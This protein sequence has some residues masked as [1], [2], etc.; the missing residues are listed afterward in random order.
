MRLGSSCFVL[1][2]AMA[3]GGCDSGGG[4]AS[5]SATAMVSAAN[6]TAV[7]SAVL[8]SLL[9]TIEAADNA[10]VLVLGAT[11]STGTLLG[12]FGGEAEYLWRD[13]DESAAI[14]S[15]D[16][17]EALFADYLDDT[18]VLSDGWLGVQ[19]VRVA[20][21]PA[22][23]T[24]W[25]TE[26]TV[27]VDAFAVESG[28]V[29]NEFRGELRMEVARTPTS[30]YSRIVV[31]SSMAS[32]AATLSPGSMLEYGTYDLD[33]TFLARAAGFVESDA[34][35]GAVSFA[36]T[37]PLGGFLF[38][39]VPSRGVLEVRG[40]AGLMTITLVDAST[41]RLAVDEDGDGVIDD[42]QIVDWSML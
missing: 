6:S 3:V 29:R 42:E 10:R 18:F 28:G 33:F 38:E 4:T 1:F 8:R 25:T 13:R 16:E 17:V 22:V 5:P 41:V 20:G 31:A 40:E 27:G 2:A 11:A 15:G 12:A 26:A 30:T 14:S 36:V 19:C 9:G 37:A 32:A 7:A 23:H 39:A 24:T 21:N 34:F 35:E